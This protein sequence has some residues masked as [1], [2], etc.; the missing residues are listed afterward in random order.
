MLQRHAFEVFHGDE[1]GTIALADL[2]D[3]ADVG[4][5]ESRGGAGFSPEAFERG[6]V[7]SDVIGKEFQGDEPT[8]REVFGFVDHTHAATAEL[9]ENAVVRD[10]LPDHACGGE[11]EECY[12][13]QGWKSKGEKQSS[14]RQASARVLTGEDAR[15]SI[16]GL[17]LAVGSKL[18]CPFFVA[19]E[20]SGFKV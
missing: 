2:I 17:I 18:K 20:M 8:E 6:S 7:L 12:E 13:R 9:L 16:G 11:V 1:A 19:S 4:M 14:H 15:L 3:S 5:V 10:G